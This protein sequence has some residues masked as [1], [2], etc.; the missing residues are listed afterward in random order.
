[1]SAAIAAFLRNGYLGTSMDQIAAAAAVSKQTVYKH[2]A[3][4]E[5]LFTQLILDTMTRTV[6]QLIHD[7]ATALRD[8][9]GEPDLERDLTTL[10]HTLITALW[11]PDVLQ[12]RRLVI[13]E[14]ARF[15]HLG[16]AYWKQ[17]FEGGMVALADSL[18]TLADRGHLHLDDPRLAAHHF[19]GLVLW[20]PMNHAMFTGIDKPMPPA[21]LDHL[22]TTGV[23]TFLAAYARTPARRK[24]RR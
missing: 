8:G 18:R 20:V 16:Q 6:D 1:M 4:K 12:L 14:A 10:A 2:F 17:G 22:A 5:Q 15:P 23:R 3:D 24:P 19:A 9:D 21:E 13:S 7:T 11:Q